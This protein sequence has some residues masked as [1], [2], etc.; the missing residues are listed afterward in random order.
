[1]LKTTLDAAK[2]LQQAGFKVNMVVPNAMDGLNKTDWN[3]VLKQQGT[4]AIQ[5]QIEAQESITLKE[6]A[7][8]IDT[9]KT[10]INLQKPD[11]A[12]QTPEVNK[13]IE[14]AAEKIAA[15]DK[16]IAELEK[17]TTAGVIKLLSD[18]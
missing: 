12:A 14:Q 3:D 13:I 1:M 8:L 11:A 17:G 7:Y 5:K 9:S 2:K 16:E 6:R 10:T 18:N 4:Q 15:L